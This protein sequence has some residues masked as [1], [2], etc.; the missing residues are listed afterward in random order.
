V[1]YSPNADGPDVSHWQHVTNVAAVPSFGLASCKLAEGRSYMDPTAPM[2]IDLF[3]S[4]GVRNLGVYFWIRADSTVE[5]QVVNLINRLRQVGLD[6]EGQLVPGVMIQLDWERTPGVR[7]VT[8][9]EVELFC[10]LVHVRYGDRLIVYGSDWLPGFVAWRAKNPTF[11]LWYANY[12]LGTLPTGGY[13]EC[14][15]YGATVWQYTSKFKGGGIA[16][17][18]PGKPLTD[19][20][21]DMNHVFDWATL[22]RLCLNHTPSPP[23]LTVPIWVA[24]TGGTMLRFV[25]D[26]ANDDGTRWVSNGQVRTATTLAHANYLIRSKQVTNLLDTADMLDADELPPLAG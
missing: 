14:I 15:K 25:G 8:V 12:N 3:R 4:K 10:Y 24:S 2:W 20:G 22:D 26:K 23:V 13:A 21:Y 11:P 6:V 7:D 18:T 5:Q 17:G 9:A 19:T 16:S 1:S